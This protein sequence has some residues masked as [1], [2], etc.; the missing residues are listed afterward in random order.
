[1]DKTIDEN[2]LGQKLDW[3]SGNPIR[4]TDNGLRD[5]DSYADEGV[6]DDHSKEDA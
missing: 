1:M 3:L 6:H 2:E 4:K 5:G